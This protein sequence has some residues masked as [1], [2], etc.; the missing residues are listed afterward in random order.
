MLAVYNIGISN[1]KEKKMENTNLTIWTKQEELKHMKR[2]L[3]NAKRRH[4]RQQ[5][6]LDAELTEEYQMV[7][8]YHEAGI[9]ELRE[10]GV[11]YRA[12]K[13]IKLAHK[14]AS[15]AMR[16]A[17]IQKWMQK[18]EIDTAYERTIAKEIAKL[19]KEI[20]TLQNVEAA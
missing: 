1:K 18:S 9:N 4:K 10:L 8:N 11:A 6:K 12:L 16:T 19:E 14:I 17:N 20:Q 15:K 3:A 13:K 7:N 2:E 5:D